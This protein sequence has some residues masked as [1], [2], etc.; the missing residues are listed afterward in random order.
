MLAQQ[1]VHTPALAKAEGVIAEADARALFLRLLHEPAG[2]LPPLRREQRRIAR[3][4]Q[5][6]ALSALVGMGVVDLVARDAHAGHLL[7]LPA[8]PLLGQR[9]AEPPEER[10]DAKARRRFLESRQR[11][12]VR[13]AV[14]LSHRPRRHRAHIGRIA[15]SQIPGTRRPGERAHRDGREQQL[16]REFHFE[17]SFIHAVCGQLLDGV[18]V[19]DGPGVLRPNSM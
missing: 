3:I 11:I 4:G 1:F 5:P 9:I 13:G 12:Q 18:F 14:G 7:Q 19:C 10:H 6:V 8:E 16:K 15:E 17:K 2:Q